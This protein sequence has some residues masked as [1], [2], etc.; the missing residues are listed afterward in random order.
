MCTFVEI[1]HTLFKTWGKNVT[2]KFSFFNLLLRLIGKLS[3]LVEQFTET[4]VS[5]KIFLI[6]KFGKDRIQLKS[7]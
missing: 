3:I 7:N 1:I 2:D 5:A 4:L 6:R